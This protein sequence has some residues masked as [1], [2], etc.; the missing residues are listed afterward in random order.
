MKHLFNSLQW[1]LFMLMGSIVIPVGVAGSFNLDPA[2][3]VSFVARTLF[4]LG[5]AGILQA[6]FGHKLPIQEGPAGVWWGIFVLY[7]GIG[8]MMFGSNT[9]T[10]RVLEFCFILSGIIFIILSLLRVVEKIARLFTP[11]VMGAYLVL[12][13]I[14][15]SG[16]FMRGMMG[17]SESH[18]TIDPL[19][20]VLSIVT[21][22]ITYIV[23]RH[24]IIGNYATLCS[25]IGGWIL[26]IIF[27]KANPVMHTE[28]FIELPQIFPF[29][30]PRI[31]LGMIVNVFLLTLLLLTNLVA[32]VKVVQIVFDSLNKKYE[33][34]L[35]QTSFMSGIIHIL[36]GVFGGIGPV[37][38]SGS[39]AFIA[40]T[41]TT[42]RMPFIVGNLLIILISLS[43]L[44]T[45]Y[46]AALPI[47]V[48][49]A[50]L[51]PT[52]GIGMFMIGISQIESAV[53][54]AARNLTVGL[55][56]FVGIGIMFLPA[57]AFKG[58]P[59]ALV[60]L[61]S[62]GLIVGTFIAVLMDRI[63]P[64]MTAPAPKATAPA[65]ESDKK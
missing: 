19:I 52:F 17:I 55:T 3:I 39:A 32:S 38:I 4:V 30:V 9:E 47:A 62:N 13:V 65:A 61:L 40:H 53:N 10:L 26:F 20:V 57:T 25:I 6:C 56:W 44:I 22:A 15:L 45:S 31:E 41:K 46:F 8:S 27:D 42:E 16:S 37:P 29:G 59:P 12:L 58:M 21:I 48:G 60:S 28:K 54:K 18:P 11:T 23:R 64:S 51:V 14:Q 34:R 50:S 33:S 36:A 35:N 63:N 2:D 43:P 5:V 49:F 7:A 24:R 1:M